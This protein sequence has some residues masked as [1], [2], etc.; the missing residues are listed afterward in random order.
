MNKSELLAE[1]KNS[2]E[3]SLNLEKSQ[4]EQLKSKSV[5]KPNVAYF[6]MEYG[7]DQ[8]LR[9]YAGGLGILAGDYV[10]AAGELGLPMVAVGL[11][12]KYGYYDQIIGTNSKIAVQ[13]SPRFYNFV[14]DTGIR[15]SVPVSNHSVQ[16]AVLALP[17]KI[18]QTCPLYLLSTDIPENDY[19]SQSITHSLYEGN[20]RTRLAQEIVLGYGGVKALRELGFEIDVYHFNEGHAV[21]AGFE[22]IEEKIRAGNSFEESY[23]QTQSQIVFTTHTPVKAGNEEHPLKLMFEMSCFPPSIDWEKAKT[24]GGG[25]DP[26]NMTVA[27]LKLSRI[28]N[29]VSQLHS[30]VAKKMWSWVEDSSPIIGIT[31]AIHLK[32][33]QDPEFGRIITAEEALKRKSEMRAE[34]VEFIQAQTGVLLKKE[35]LTICWARRFADYKRAWLILKDQDRL[36]KLLENNQLQLIFAGKPHPDSKDAHELFN[37]ILRLSKKLPNLVILPGYEIALSKILKQGSDLWLNCPRRPLEASGTSGMSAALNGTLHFSTFDGWWVEGYIP[38]ENGWVIGDD[39]VY[40][41][42]NEQDQA[43]YQSMMTTLEEEIIPTF[44]HNSLEWG[45][46]ML[47]AKKVS[48]SQFTSSRMILEYYARLYQH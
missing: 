46:K 17:T 6:C 7:I 43:D 42:V 35:V 25:G 1:N 9:T 11:L 38:G 24:I 41:S 29:G 48:E 40:N 32:S 30:Q 5:Y 18:F 21:F 20:Q 19:L 12:Y 26:F 47:K 37:H 15:V 8:S 28:A 39:R 3:V 33:W 34:L 31:N 23:R 10:K 22:L 27:G 44:Y 36:R 45:R 13:Y 2:L 4:I 16:V 14:E